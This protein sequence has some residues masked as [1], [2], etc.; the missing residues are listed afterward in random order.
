MISF[1]PRHKLRAFVC[2]A[3]ASSGLASAVPEPA[4]A[5]FSSLLGG[6]M[7]GAFRPGYRPHGGYYQRGRRY[8]SHHSRSRSD[9]D[10]ADD[11]SS[12]DISSD[13]NNH[14]LAALAPATA[15]QT[16]VFKSIASSTVLGPVGS[17]DDLKQPGET[18]KTE[19]GLEEA[20]R[21]FVN[22]IG[23]LIEKFKN[24]MKGQKSSNDGDITEYAIEQAVDDAYKHAN[25]QRFETFLGENW[26]ADRLRVMILDH[27]NAEIDRLFKGTNQGQ[28]RMSDLR[29][30]I[31][32]SAD[33]IYSR[34]FET[35]ELLASNR[36]SALFVQRLYQTH[37]DLIQG[38][39]R[40]GTERMLMQASAAVT[41]K[42]GDLVR[43]EENAYALRYRLQRILFDCLSENVEKISSAE[44]GVATPEEIAQRISNV[45]TQKCMA[46]IDTQF[47]DAN[48][49]LKPQEPMPLR[50]IWTAEGPNRDD[51]MYGRPTS[52]N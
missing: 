34:L 40:E 5:Q 1:R 15:V 42:F 25:L 4:T 2:V 23:N 26:T 50:V 11:N 9:S 37:G 38:D 29:T 21:D 31:Q 24:Q 16:G 27:V 32:K 36:S 7:S 18:T 39:V 47:K 41:G 49:K 20:K 52:A 28:V 30:M 48:G 13:R 3:V 10:R 17:T 8:S 51:S 43:R 12:Q 33:I 6:L 22:A 14:V 46:W 35:S 45:E 44:Q 19:V